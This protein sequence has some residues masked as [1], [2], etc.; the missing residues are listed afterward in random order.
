MQSVIL[1]RLKKEFSEIFGKEISR[2]IKQAARTGYTGVIK[3][4]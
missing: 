4:N 1:K 3:R 2:K